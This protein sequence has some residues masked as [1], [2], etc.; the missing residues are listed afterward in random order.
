MVC[1]GLAEGIDSVGNFNCITPTHSLCYM[2]G[3]NI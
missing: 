3:A 1:R 2:K